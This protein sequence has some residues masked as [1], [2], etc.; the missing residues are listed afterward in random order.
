MSDP[1]KNGSDSDAFF[2]FGSGGGGG[3]IVCGILDLSATNENA[4]FAVYT[5]SGG[6]AVS[7]D[8]TRYRNHNPHTGSD[9][10]VGTNSIL[11]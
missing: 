8:C 3:G 7:N 6:S 2:C 10:N 1:D 4:C 11:C 9:G 5:G